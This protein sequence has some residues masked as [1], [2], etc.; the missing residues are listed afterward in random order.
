MQPVEVYEVA[1]VT[2]NHLRV[3]VAGRAHL[4]RVQREGVMASLRMGAA[5][6]AQ[7]MVDAINDPACEPDRLTALC[8]E[9]EGWRGYVILRC[10]SDP[11]WLLDTR[12]RYDAAE[13]GAVRGL[14][15]S[16]A[17][18]LA[19]VD[20][21]MEAGWTAR[22]VAGV[23]GRLLAHAEQTLRDVPSEAEVTEAEG[24]SGPKRGAST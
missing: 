23:C 4:L 12:T 14:A 18:G 15:P 11:A 5:R 19:C 6:A 21:L 22:D 9:A 7:A 3:E 24:F 10:W 2:A 8:E 1:K 16:V 13:F 17:A 20:E